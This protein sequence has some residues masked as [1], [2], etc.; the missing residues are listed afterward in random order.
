VLQLVRGFVA[1][2]KPVA[3]ICHGPQILA[4]A[5][6]LNGRRA[7]AYRTVTGELEAAGAVVED[8][9]VVVDGRIITS[10]QPADL[11]AFIDAVMRMLG[12]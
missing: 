9:E 4:A 11:P 7:T 5:G 12:R 8:R 1:A 3:A 10:R 2:G 6:V